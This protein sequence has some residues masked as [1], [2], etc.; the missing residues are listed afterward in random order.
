MPTQRACGGAQ[1]SDATRHHSAA[2]HPH[3]QLPSHSHPPAG[4]GGIVTS[5]G[6]ACQLIGAITVSVLSCRLRGMPG[7]GEGRCCA[8]APAAAG[9]SGDGKQLSGGAHSVG[10]SASSASPLHDS[11]AVTSPLAGAAKQHHH[12]HGGSRGAKAA[13]AG[14]DGAWPGYAFP[15]DKGATAISSSP[16]AAK[17]PRLTSPRVAGSSTTASPP[18]SSAASTGSAPGAPIQPPQA[19]PEKGAE[20]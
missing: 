8:V 16:P 3:A 20:A 12:H 18:P 9:G 2:P 17:S 4:Y 14:A 10:S 15:V 1:R 11:V 6:L 7:V 5:V 19:R 13:G